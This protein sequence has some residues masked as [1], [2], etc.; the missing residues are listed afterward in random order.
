MV[1]SV[2]QKQL[3]WGL[4]GYQHCSMHRKSQCYNPGLINPSPP[5][6]YRHVI[7]IVSYNWELGGIWL[8]VMWP[9]L[10]NLQCIAQISITSTL[11]PECTFL[12]PEEKEEKTARRSLRQNPRS[13]LRLPSSTRNTNDLYCHVSISQALYVFASYVTR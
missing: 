9:F 6:P 1:F 11:D 7:I 3:Q 2:S 8:L 10:T 5:D 12:S 4:C 13:S